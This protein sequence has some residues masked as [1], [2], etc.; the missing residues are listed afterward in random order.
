MSS[1]PVV[2]VSLLGIVLV[3]MVLP[4]WGTSPLDPAVVAAFDRLHQHIREAGSVQGDLGDSLLKKV[5]NAENAYVRGHVCTAANVLSAFSHQTQALRKGDRAARAEDF[6]NQAWTLRLM[7]LRA[8]PDAPCSLPAVQSPADVSLG[9]S[10]NQQVTGTIHFPDPRLL[11]IDRGGETWTQ[12]DFP[13]IP[14]IGEPPGAPSIPAFRRLIAVPRGAEAAITIGD[15]N[16]A[17]SFFLNLYP[18]QP[19]AEDAQPPDAFGD[20]EPPLASYGDK[21]FV[22]DARLYATNA[23]LP[24]NPCRLSDAGTFRDLQIVQLEC[25]AA[26]YNPVTDEVKIFRSIDFQ[27]LFRGGTGVFLTEASLGP[28]ES[29]PDAYIGSV[30]NSDAVS[31][32]VGPDLRE[33]GCPGEELL[34]LTHPDFR[35]QADQL[36]AWKRDKG[37]ATSVFNVNDG[38][39]PGPDTNEEI[40]AFIEHR[41]ATCKVRPSYVL[42]LGD[43][44]H[45]PT[46]YEQR[47]NYP[48][49]TLIPSDY[50]Y[51]R[52]PP[53]NPD[54]LL[55][56]FDVYPDLGV[57]RIPVDTPDEAQ[58]VVNKLL[59]YEGS[60]P[61]APTFYHMALFASDFQ[62][63]RT[64]TNVVP[65]GSDQRAFVQTSEFLRDTLMGYGKEGQRVYGKTVDAGDN[66]TDP[67]SPP[68]TGDPTPRFYVDGMTALPADLA[69]GFPWDG[70]PDD[71]VAGINEGRF[72]VVHVDH[73]FR[74]GWGTPN[75]K[76]AYLPSLTNATLYPFVLSINCSSGHFDEETDNDG[77]TSAEAFAEQILFKP[78]AGAIGVIASTRMSNTGVNDVLARGWVDAM[79]P[80]T[81]SFGNSQ[82]L[83]RVGDILNHGKLYMISQLGLTHGNL[84][85]HLNMYHAFGDPT[86]EVWTGSPFH[87]PQDFVLI[88]I[89]DFGL[90]IHYAVDGAVITALQEVRGEVIPVGRAMVDQGVAHMQFFSAPIEGVPLILSASMKGAVSTKLLLH[91]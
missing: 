31:R 84:L 48:P 88:P 24:P 20:E 33:I 68:Y 67:P 35:D 91:E 30:L 44:E 64:D 57:G 54:P 83:V 58:A 17:E 69:P 10:D 77:G 40:D 62:C 55:L 90:E 76:T 19:P 36:A 70:S 73:G 45:I 80:D 22:K 2:P 1:R 65:E 7:M 18:L 27:V 26:Q 37:I 34:I 51:A 61:F 5:Q 41:Y 74:L 3:F 15:P 82:S 60:P 85:N 59:Q 9:E 29:V 79:F 8:H 23:F 39:G 52:I 47:V 86:L 25:A 81:V 49:G 72:L 38:A 78:N 12:L 56:L 13:G 28:F 32:Y 63:C 75:F 43:A 14:N 21:P 16:L 89:P 6:G 71:V 46:F 4:A 87:L 53:A 50:R 66:S 42:L 11:T